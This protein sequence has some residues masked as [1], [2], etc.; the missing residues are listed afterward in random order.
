MLCLGCIF[1]MDLISPM[2][3]SYTNWDTEIWRIDHLSCPW[4]PFQEFEDF[5]LG[6][7]GTF[8]GHL[9]PLYSVNLGPFPTYLFFLPNQHLYPFNCITPP[10]P[11]SSKV[12]FSL[13]II[14]LSVCFCSWWRHSRGFRLGGWRW[15]EEES[16]PHSA[17]VSKWIIY[18]FNQIF[19]PQRPAPVDTSSVPYYAEENLSPPSVL[20]TLSRSP[21]PGR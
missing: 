18:F 17:L 4:A 14:L 5:V 8:L 1:T 12:H 13:L 7:P 10:I 21:A 3:N 19:I 9:Y 11:S 20:V 6:F 16:G 2:H 15:E